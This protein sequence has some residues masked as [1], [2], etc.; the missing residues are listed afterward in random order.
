[1]DYQFDPVVLEQRL[2]ELESWKRLAF[3]VLLLER[4]APSFFRFEYETGARGG[5]ILRGT[6]A[7]AWGLLEGSTT[8]FAGLAARDC[9]I[10]IPD[11]EHYTSIYTSSALD[12]MTIAC[13][14]LDY[15]D[16]GKT[17]FL[18]ESAS[19]RRDTVDMFLQLTG[20]ITSTSDD[21]EAR[22]LAHPLMQEELGF[23]SE[24]LAFLASV[25][26]QQEIGWPAVLKRSI[27]LIDLR[28]K[29]SE[30]EVSPHNL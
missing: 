13:N 17:S 3:G 15:I 10:F 14:L 19:L 29:G 1:M 4:A 6:L 28:E 7:K 24:D 27:D 20:Q 11:T 18:I 23:Q 16:S 5:A 26:F 8:V 2:S 9:E 22:L 30:S 21:F 12:G 25:S